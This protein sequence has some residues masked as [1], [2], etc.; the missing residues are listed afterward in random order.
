MEPRNNDK[1][2]WIQKKNIYLHEILG[3]LLARCFLRRGCSW[4]KALMHVKY[5]TYVRE[6]TNQMNIE[7][8]ATKVLNYRL[9]HCTVLPDFLSFSFSFFNLCLL[10]CLFLIV[11]RSCVMQASKEVKGVAQRIDTHG[12]FLHSVPTKVQQKN[13]VCARC[14]ALPHVIV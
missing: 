1:K 4:R 11:S 12:K 3:V 8:K 10:L 6:A 5:C 13:R 7:E 9:V 2:Y 14:L